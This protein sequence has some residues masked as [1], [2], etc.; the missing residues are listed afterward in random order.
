[1]KISDEPYNHNA[2]KSM[3]S[4]LLKIALL[5]M[6]VLTATCLVARVVGSTQPPNSTLRGF[7]EGCDDKPQPCWYGIVP[8][9][10]TP[11]EGEQILDSLGY[12]I[13][14]TPQGY[15]HDTGWYEGNSL[16]CSQIT[17]LSSIQ[18]NADR[19]NVS[20]IYYLSLHECHSVYLGDFVTG[21]GQPDQFYFWSWSFFHDQLLADV[22]FDYGASGNRCLSFM[23]KVKVSGFL[24]RF[25]EGAS[26]RPIDTKY[27]WHGFLPFQQY[28]TKFGYEDCYTL[29]REP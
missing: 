17:V 3:P 29:A 18:V 22:D 15:P 2:K 24:I 25:I 7:T 19:P 12:K 4:F 13:T 28:V 5:I 23:P 11:E 21:L 10:T 14:Q 26:E 9:I 1:M 6:L 27:P 20:L 16:P 8:G